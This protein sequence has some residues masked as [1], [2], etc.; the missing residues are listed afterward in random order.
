MRRS[1]CKCSTNSNR[2]TEDN[3]SITNTTTPKWIPSG[4]QIPS[5]GQKCPSAST[6]LSRFAI[7]DA[8]SIIVYLIFGSHHVKRRIKFWMKPELR[9][10]KFWSG[11][12]SVATQMLGIV[13]TALV[14]RQNGYKV[15]LWNLIQIWAVRPRASLFIGNMAHTKEI[16]GYMN[17]AL[18]NIVVEVVVC[19]LGMA[20]V[21][22][23]A[24][25]ALT[26]RP[27]S[28]PT[29]FWVI[30]VSSFIMQFSVLAE[31]I[32]ALRILRRSVRTKG[33][34]QYHDI[35]TLKWTARFIIPITC[36]CSYLIWTAFLYSTSGVYCLG[37]LKYVDAIWSVVPV[38]TNLLRLVV[39]EL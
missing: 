24:V 36:I 34:P 3:M 27:S 31:I 11:L 38:V 7:Y 5:T 13:G 20:F 37:S 33:K 32:A 26:H 1:S 21:G 10:W 19:G 39:E 17:G 28:P 18:D 22:N 25:Q 6:V 9:P 2:H 16:W 29:W 35:D 4:F 14:I 30:T 23:V 8:I 12:T 15:S